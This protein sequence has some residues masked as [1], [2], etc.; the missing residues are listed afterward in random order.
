[1][2]LEVQQVAERN[3]VWELGEALKAKK[4]SHEVEWMAKMATGQVEP[5]EVGGAQVGDGRL[6]E[7]DEVEGVAVGGAQ[8]FTP[9][10]AGYQDDESDKWTT[11]TDDV[12]IIQDL[13]DQWRSHFNEVFHVVEESH[14]NEGEEWL[15]SFHTD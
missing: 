5:D 8:A 11:D 2:S 12:E 6:V 14:L 3:V 9:G 13:Y 15:R 1:M 10:D 7:T 4:A